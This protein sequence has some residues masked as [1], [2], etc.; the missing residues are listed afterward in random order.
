MLADKRERPMKLSRMLLAA[1]LCPLIMS[2]AMAA[3]P[4]YAVGSQ[5]RAFSDEGRRNWQNTDA[6]PVRTVIWYPIEARLRRQVT[7]D[8]DAHF[9]EKSVIPKAPILPTVAKCPL[10]LLSHGASGHAHALLWFAHYFAER[11]YIVA[12]V[13]HHGD[14][15]M[16]SDRPPPGR[17]HFWE[18]PGDLTVALTQLLVDPELAPRIDANRIGAAGYSAGGGTVIQLAGAVFRPD[19]LNALCQAD[20][21]R[22][23]CD[24]PSFIKD[25]LSKIDALAKV[26][27]VIRASIARRGQSFKDERI[28][29]AFAIAPALGRIFTEQGLR[30]V[31]IPIRIVASRADKITPPALDSY[32]YTQ[33]ISSARLTVVSEHASHFSFGNECTPL[34]QRTEEICRDAAGVDRAELHRTVGALAY[35]F[36]EEVWRQNG[37]A[38]PN[39]QSAGS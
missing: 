25:Q 17:L 32:P 39:A 11:G 7:A 35:E 37:I 8:A 21:A 9:V 3:E 22:A 18:R 23:G 6:R 14:T 30:A 20:P 34:G 26:D 27:P 16:E 36:F 29:A 13:T 10:L 19:E 2:C 31:N 33:W 5:T 1:A 28:K 24:I 4:R 38:A 15:S 12:A